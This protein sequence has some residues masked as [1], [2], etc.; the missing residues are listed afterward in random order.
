MT[1][2]S[3]IADRFRRL[4]TPAA[5]GG[6][7]A[8]GA[9]PQLALLLAVALLGGQLAWSL[10]HLWPGAS[11]L[12]GAAV[13]VTPPP[14]ADVAELLRAHLFGASEAATSGGGEV[15]Q[16]RVPLIL[17]GTL[18]VRDPRQGLAIVGATAQAGK[19]YA[20]GAVLP[21]GVKL[22]EVYVDHV[23]LEHDGVLEMLLLPRQL[24]GGAGPGNTTAMSPPGNSGE[25]PLADSVQK[26]IAQG[27]EVIGEVLRPM[28]TYVN[29]QLKGFRVYPGRNRAKFE[30]LQLRAGDLVTQINSVPLSDPQRGMEILRTLGNAGTAQVTVERGAITQQLTVDASQVVGLGQP[31]SDA[32]GP[33]APANPTPSPE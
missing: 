26:L 19:L 20:V 17:A 2:P 21:G 8:A 29:G 15:Q 6:A 33:P 16:T 7:R 22:H 24:N 12:P 28:P 23:V 32:P 10:W 25:P 14:A 18:A 5:P 30:Q 13:R 31:N 3:V 27:P 4:V 1:P 9:G 11:R